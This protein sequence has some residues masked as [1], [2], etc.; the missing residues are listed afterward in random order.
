MSGLFGKGF[1]L[2]LGEWVRLDFD[3]LKILNSETDVVVFLE[4][5]LVKLVGLISFLSDIFVQS[6]VLA[7]I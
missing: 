6:F 7:L 4:L 2:S 3:H 1:L 5:M